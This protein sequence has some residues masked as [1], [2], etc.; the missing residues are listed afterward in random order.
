[1]GGCS[2]VRKHMPGV[3]KTVGFIFYAR[4][5]KQTNKQTKQKHASDTVKT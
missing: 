1:M 2:I 4:K 5:N 3:Y